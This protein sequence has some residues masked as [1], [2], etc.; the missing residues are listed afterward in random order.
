MPRE[1]NHPKWMLCPASGLSLK[2][3]I[4]EAG[5]RLQ[6]ATILVPSR[7][8]ITELSI[9]INSS[10]T[11]SKTSSFLIQNLSEIDVAKSS[12]AAVRS[13]GESGSITSII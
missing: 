4:F 5:E 11:P 3:G 8:A 13:L 2:P 7:T 1:A 6:D 10:Y 9:L 12:S